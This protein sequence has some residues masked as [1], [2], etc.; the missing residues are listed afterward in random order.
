MVKFD[1][2]LWQC[3]ACGVTHVHSSNLRAHIEAHHYS[4]G[5]TCAIC[6]RTM[7][8]RNAYKGHMKIKH[9]LS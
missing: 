3:G 1:K 6:E 8:T 4:P 7:T 2:K 5:Y 9:G